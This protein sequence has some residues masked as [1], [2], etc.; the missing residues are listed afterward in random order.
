MFKKNLMGAAAGLFIILILNSAFAGYTQ[1]VVIG[2]SFS[3]TGNAHIAIPG[4]SPT[5]PY[6]QARFSNGP[7]YID[8]LASA[9]GVSAASS[10]KGG[11]NYAYASSVTS[12]S[13]PSPVRPPL[14][15]PCKTSSRPI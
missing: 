3:D 13:Q 2:D 14:C 7:N 1:I 6:Y 11:T 5:P 12:A 15:R 10:L 8:T 9:F 4:S